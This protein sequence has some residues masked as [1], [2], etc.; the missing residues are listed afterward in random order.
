MAEGNEIALKAG[1]YS[2][3]TAGV[4]TL[5]FALLILLDFIVKTIM[6]QF[7]VCFFLAVSYVIAANALC[8]VASPK[9]KFWGQA[10]VSFAVMYAV[11]ICLVYYS[12]LTVVRQGLVPKESL[13]LIEFTPGTWLFA[14]DM[15]GYT[16][17]A[18]S[19]IAA[20]FLFGKKG[21]ERSIRVLLIIHGALAIPVSIFP[22]LPLFGTAAAVHSANL[23]GS[24][25]LLAWCA[26]FAPI[27]FLLSR[28]FSLIDAKTPHTSQ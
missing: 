28:Y 11:F 21:L 17:L 8:S 14:V 9:L 10:A 16:F 13:P 6:F 1:K 15:L 20:A 27:C 12:Q 22:A 26:V 7:V 3:V 19:T 2:S 4:C 5:L 18:L 25:A 23:G 24:L